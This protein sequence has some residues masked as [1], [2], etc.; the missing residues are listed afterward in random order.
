[1]SFILPIIPAILGAIGAAAGVTGAGVTAG[2]SIAAGLAITGAAVGAGLSIAGAVGGN[3]SGAGSGYSKPP[4]IPDPTVAAKK[5]QEAQ[6]S[7][8][9]S[10]LAAGGQTN[11]TQGTAMLQPGQTGLKTLLGG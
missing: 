1:M 5:A 11:L 2:A 3:D 10:I 6:D 8:R 4:T 9:R 7:R